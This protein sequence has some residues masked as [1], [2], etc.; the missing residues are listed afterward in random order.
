MVGHHPDLAV[1][2]Q[3]GFELAAVQQRFGGAPVIERTKGTCHLIIRV[4]GRQHMA[5]FPFRTHGS[6]VGPATAPSA[7]PSP[8]D[9][10]LAN[11]LSFGRANIARRT[12]PRPLQHPHTALIFPHRTGR[13]RPH[14]H[15]GKVRCV[16]KRGV[17]PAHPQRRYRFH[18]H[19]APATGRG[20]GDQT[21]PRLYGDAP[22]HLRVT[23]LR[24]RSQRKKP[25]RALL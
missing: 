7:R 3:Y 10:G 15:A 18:P 13:G 12:N 9:G 22:M 1:C 11:A 19:Q 8:R 17:G 6:I 5:Q 23:R 20:R 16:E 14:R 21:G 24:T 25:Q 2:P 4:V